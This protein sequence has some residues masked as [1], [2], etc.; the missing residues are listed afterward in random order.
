MI[1][2]IFFDV[3]GTLF[4]S[5]QKFFDFLAERFGNRELGNKAKAKFREKIEKFSGQNFRPFL[6]LVREAA[7]ETFGR[8]FSLFEITE[9][10]E[11]YIEKEMYI[12][13]GTKDVLE[14]LG[15]NYKLGIISNGSRE[16]VAKQLSFFGISKFFEVVITSDDAKAFKPDRKIFLLALNRLKIKP[17]NA[18]FVGNSKNDMLGAKKVGIL[19]ISLSDDKDAD[20]RIKNLKELERIF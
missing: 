8:E 6:E 9:I 4:K 3:N 16:I 13:R 14:N 19:A 18:A 12:E 10:Y 11:D 20:F 5:N 17:E 15:R 2:A 1:K 7:S